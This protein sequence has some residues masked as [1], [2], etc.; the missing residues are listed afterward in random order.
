M[1]DLPT[2][3]PPPT[4]VPV[5]GTGSPENVRARRLT[6]LVVAW[7]SVLGPA[8]QVLGTTSIGL[9]LNNQEELNYQTSVLYYFLGTAV[10]V[11]AVALALYFVLLK[12]R[13]PATLLWLYYF[14]GFAFLGAVEIHQWEAGIV[15]KLAA[16]TALLA[17]YILLQFAAYRWWSVHRAASYF[18]VVAIA[19]VS[20]D[21]FELATRRVEP[22]QEL[23]I[24]TP[25][26]AIG[27]D[28]EQ[29]RNFYHIVF[30][31]YQ[32]D[33]FDFTLDSEL[34][35]LLGGFVFFDNAVTMFG[36]T[37]MSLASLFS[38]RSY[39]FESS[40]A[41]YQRSAF[42]GQQSMLRQLIDKGY[43]TEAYLHEG[44]LNFDVPFH[45][46]R[47]HRPRAGYGRNV[48]N[49][50]FTGLWIYANFPSMLASLMIE[51]ELFAN[52]EAQN[53]VDLATPIRS[54]DAF[55]YL[56]R[57][58]ASQSGAGR[59]VFAHF[60]LPHFPNVLDSDCRYSLDGT[61]TRP[62]QQ[63][64]CANKLMVEL[65]ATL[66]RLGRLQ[67][68]LIVIQ[69]DHGS[70]YRIQDG[71]LRPQNGMKDYADGWNT[72]RARSLL[73]IKPPGRGRS[74]TLVRNSAPVSLLD[75]FPTVGEALGLDVGEAEGV[76]LFDTQEVAAISARQR[77]Y[78]FFEKK[79]RAGWTDEMVRFRVEGDHVVRDGIQ[80][81]ANNPRF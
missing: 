79:T 66:Q 67:N 60:I 31:E 43:V 45:H 70:R 22:P 21:V 46:V 27:R 23:E 17:G 40:Q 63:A 54:L 14:S 25:V 72:A 26:R 59:Y 64:G 34:A 10:L 24:T 7:L 48:S 56:I 71:R 49:E 78:Y 13:G 32:T 50:L 35:D 81:L 55:D 12:K 3:E 69:S 18:A 1:D 16:A 11:S 19:F 36:R 38:G 39:D 53:V 6:L 52:F 58:E 42:N 77:W 74:G 30:D 47:L 15:H 41:E 9:Y 4:F 68:S 20:V 2:R 51:E 80:T 73:L 8:W 65:L 33:V 57:R 44:L 75:V 62:E 37:R 29:L 28:S 61:K 76:N 5:E